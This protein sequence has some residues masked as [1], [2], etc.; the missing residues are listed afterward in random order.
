MADSKG[1]WK[2]VKMTTNSEVIK[3]NPKFKGG[4]QMIFFWQSS[5]MADHQLCRKKFL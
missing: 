1:T 3:G 5:V 2:K 4:I